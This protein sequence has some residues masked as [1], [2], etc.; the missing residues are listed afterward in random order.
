M[1]QFDFEYY[2]PQSAQE[3]VKLFQSLE[4]EG[5]KPAYCSGGTEQLTLVRMNVIHTN[6]VI[7][8]K[9]IPECRTLQFE[10]HHLALGSALTLTE[11]TENG[12]FPLL[13]KAAREVADHTVRNKITLGGNICGQIFYREAV[14]PFLLTDSKVVTVGD[15]GKKRYLVFDQQLK[16]SKGEILISLLIEERYLHQPFASIKVRQRWDTGYPL[17]TI[18]ALEID[19]R[20]RCAFS[21][22]CSYPFRSAEV[23]SALNDEALPVD[24]RV[25]EAINRLPGPVLDDAQ[26]SAEYRTFVIKHTLFDILGM[27]KK[28]TL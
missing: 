15:K 13:S 26:G 10:R 5:K 17:A 12:G 6:A 21:G 9:D 4:R 20:V 7:D 22:V 28:E 11:I 3:A 24:Q 27:L 25:E 16:L 19:G 23:E 8:I 14:L 2:R 1:I 18:S